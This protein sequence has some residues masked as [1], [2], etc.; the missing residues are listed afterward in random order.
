MLTALSAMVHLELPH[1]NI[2][3]KCDLADKKSLEAIL[4]PSGAMLANAL[5]KRLPPSFQKLNV[6]LANLLD[7]YDMVAFVPLDITNEDSIDSILLHIDHIL[8]F[9]ENAE[10]KEPKDEFNDND[11]DNNNDGEYG[12]GSRNSSNTGDD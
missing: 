10:P 9:G 2:L 11:N 5:N 7:N 4:S 1:I 3:T 8:Q 12:E 6:S